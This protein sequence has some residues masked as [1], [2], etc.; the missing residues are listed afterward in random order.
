ME[1]Q[2]MNSMPINID[3]ANDYSFKFLNIIFWLKTKN[4][5]N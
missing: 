1:K 3:L 5:F 4:L 2:M